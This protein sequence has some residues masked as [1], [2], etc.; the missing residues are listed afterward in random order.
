MTDKPDHEG[1]REIAEEWLRIMPHE[2]P[3]LHATRTPIL[4]RC[5]LDAIAAKERAEALLQGYKDGAYEEA[6]AGDEARAKLAAI[7]ACAS[8]VKGAPGLYLVDSDA[9]RE[10]LASTETEPS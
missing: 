4:A 10:L 1:A 5:Y 2:L 3:E 6:R 9:M 7:V 8:E